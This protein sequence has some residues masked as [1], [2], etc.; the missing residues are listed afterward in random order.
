MLLLLVLPVALPIDKRRKCLRRKRLNWGAYAQRL[1]DEGMFHKC[2][3]MSY[4]WFMA[5]AAKLEPY[6]PVD[7]KQSRNRT[8]TDP[9]THINKL[10]LCLRWLSGGSYHDIRE[11][12]PLM[13]S[14]IR[15]ASHKSKKY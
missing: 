11:N 4:P 12:S 14:S 15:F 3:K 1:L 5:L 6:L 9:I 8:G 2:F 7:E 10:Q 13:D